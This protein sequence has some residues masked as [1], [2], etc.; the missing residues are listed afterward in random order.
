MSE[1]QIIMCPAER[2]PYVCWVQKSEDAME[3]LVGGHIFTEKLTEKT[4]IA[5]H[6][7]LRN[8]IL[9]E[10]NSLPV[11]GFLGD[12]FLCG[13]EGDQLVS[14]D[15]DTKRALLRSCRDRWNAIW[16]E[17]HGN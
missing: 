5:Y 14:L 4:I 17:R 2:A 9:P 11:S 8:V 15:E 10:N 12:C 13:V 3:K 16:E 6:V 1:I 7:E